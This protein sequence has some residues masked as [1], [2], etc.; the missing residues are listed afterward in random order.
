MKPLLEALHI[1]KKFQTLTAVDDISLHVAP[2]E[3]LALLGPNG[4]GKTTTVEILEG[5][6][7][8]DSGTVKLFGQD[9]TPRSKRDLMQRVGVMLQETNLYKKLTVKETLSLFRSFFKQGLDVQ[10]AI[11]IV[12]LED[13]QNARLEE[14]SGGQKQ[15]AFLACALVNEPELL[16]LDEPTTGLDPQSRRMIWDLLDKE[17]GKGRGILLTTHYMDEAEYLADRVAIVD[18]GKIITEGSPEEL[19]R[20]YCGEQVLSFSFEDTDARHENLLEENL[21]WFKQVKKVQNRYEFIAQNLVSAIHDLTQATSKLSLKLA[22]IEMRR[23]T[24]E[25]VFLTLTGRSIRDA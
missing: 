8:P 4:A 24:L 19:I 1:K 5:L 7:S 10:Q 16:F 20:Q 12:Q 22:G 11:Q 18:H 25:D 13:K 15:R 6:Q 2:G 3:C 21:A 9:M 17:K 23:S 14:L